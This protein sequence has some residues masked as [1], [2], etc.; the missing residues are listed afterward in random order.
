MCRPKISVKIQL[1]NCRRLHV[2]SMGQIANH[3][4]SI[5]ERIANAAAKSGRPPEDITLVAVT[6]RVD[7]A[8]ILQAHLAGIREFGENYYQEA[9]EK[10]ELFGPEVRWHF[11]GRLQTNKATYVAG[12]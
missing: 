6:K 7:P 2:N 1:G 11:I 10:L 5:R 9:R 8:R 4:E 3:I 12:R